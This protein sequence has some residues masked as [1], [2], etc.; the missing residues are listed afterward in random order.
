MRGE[1]ILRREIRA[2]RDAGRLVLTYIGEIWRLRA[3]VPVGWMHSVTG[4]YGKFFGQTKRQE[5]LTVRLGSNVSI[6]NN[7][8]SSSSAFNHN[9]LGICHNALTRTPS[10]TICLVSCSEWRRRPRG[11]RGTD[12]CHQDWFMSY[13]FKIGS[14]ILS[15]VTVWLLSRSARSVII[16]VFHEGHL[17]SIEGNRIDS[18]SYQFVFPVRSIICPLHSGNE[19]LLLITFRIL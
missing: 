6:S 5:F 16:R 12:Q 13:R 3:E 17:Y 1:I 4:A 11:Q 8:P 10:L 19:K 2:F 18:A 14:R 7:Y 15:P 9:G